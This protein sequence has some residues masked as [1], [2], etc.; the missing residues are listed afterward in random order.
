MW[1]GSEELKTESAIVASVFPAAKA[2]VSSVSPAAKA[3][4]SPAAKAKK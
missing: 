4:V 2:E 3:K 1:Y